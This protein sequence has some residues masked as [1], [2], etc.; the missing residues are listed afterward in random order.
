[1]KHFF[2]LLTVLLTLTATVDAKNANL[3]INDGGVTFNVPAGFKPMP[4]NLIKVKYPRGNPPRHVMTNDSTETTI[5]FDTRPKKLPQEQVEASLKAFAEAFKKTVPGFKLKQKKVVNLG[6]QKWALIEFISNT[7]DSK[8]HNV[9][10]TTGYK[11]KMLIIN[12]NSTL[13]E[14]SKYEAGFHQSIKSIKLK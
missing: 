8:V 4:T 13:L 2:V 10:L 14:F 9:L 6:G 3:S 7:I 5:A 11:D 1:M 12:F